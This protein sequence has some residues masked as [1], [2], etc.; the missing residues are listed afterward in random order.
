MVGGSFAAHIGA[1]WFYLSEK[2]PD[3][4]PNRMANY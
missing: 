1:P 3:H 2:L 4:T